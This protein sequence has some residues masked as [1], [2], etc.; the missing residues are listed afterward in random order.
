MSKYDV[1]L[2]KEAEEL[3]KQAKEE[4][5]QKNYDLAIL[6]L[7]DAKDIYIQLGFQGQINMMDKQIARYKNV[8]D[9]E[10]KTQESS[11]LYCWRT[12]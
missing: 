2:E 6:L 9:F 5:G 8:V 12:S 1:E 4:V 10:K 7:M 11:A 3:K